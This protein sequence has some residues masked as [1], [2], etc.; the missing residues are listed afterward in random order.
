MLHE[1]KVPETGFGIAE[2][3]IVEWFKSIGE[4]V[5]EGEPIVSVET[6]KVNVEIPAPGNGVL[7]EIRFQVG[8]VIPVGEVLGIITS[9]AQAVIA[10]QVKSSRDLGESRQSG[11]EKLITHDVEIP[12]RKRISRLAKTIARK[13]GVDLLLIPSGSGP[14]GRITKEDVLKVVQQRKDQTEPVREVVETVGTPA[15]ETS[16][17]DKKVKL[18]HWRKVIADRLTTSWTEIPHHAQSIDIDVTEL[19][20][21]I[22]ETQN[23][24]SIPRM[25]YMPFIMKAIQAGT[26]VTPE[27]NA[28]CYGDHYVIRQD[29]NIGIAVDANGKLIVPVVKQVQQKSIA[30]I[31]VELKSLVA[32][33]REDKLEPQDV[34]DATITISNVGPLGLYSGF[35]IIVPPQTTIVCVG[36]V[37]ETPAA[38]DG[39]IEIRNKMFVTNSYDHRAVH[40]GPASR[41]FA[42]MRDKLENLKSLL[43]ILH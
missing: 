28:H 2:A 20:D 39:S 9:E 1:I 40:G 21:Y 5:Q 11:S 15:F 37:R 10:D 33:A 25:T 38:I 16:L 27:I 7:S 14:G 4:E 22:S 26:R 13:E 31:A 35:S 17:A 18:T 19:S 30:D 23:D 29:L 8:D 3:T 34:Q 24:A 12:K 6:E 42:E 41:F 32:R 36:A 43:L